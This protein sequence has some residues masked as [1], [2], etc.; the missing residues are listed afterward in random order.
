MK[1]ERKLFWP[2]KG[3]L[4]DGDP[5]NND[6]KHQPANKNTLMNSILDRKTRPNPKS[7]NICGFLI[8]EDNSQQQSKKDICRIKVKPPP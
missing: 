6:E 7:K 5:Q 2:N 1:Q 3:N 8:W 4:L